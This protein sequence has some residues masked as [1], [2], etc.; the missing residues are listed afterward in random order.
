MRLVFEGKTQAQKASRPS[1]CVAEV[2]EELEK[3][4]AHLG[5]HAPRVLGGGAEFLDD[6]PQV[7]HFVSCG[8]VIRRGPALLFGGI[9]AIIRLLKAAQEIGPSVRPF[10]RITHRVFSRN[11]SLI[12]EYN[13]AADDQR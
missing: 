11:R 10:T 3:G 6:Q 2:L 8:P 7:A 5:I 13:R 1:G 12:S 9:V 4:L